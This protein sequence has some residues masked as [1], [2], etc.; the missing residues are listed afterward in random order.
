MPITVND[1]G[2]IRKIGT[3]TTNDNGILRN[4]STVSVNDGGVIRTV[5]SSSKVK[6]E[7]ITPLVV[8]DDHIVIV[9]SGTGT[10]SA[11]K[12][13]KIIM[14]GNGVRYGNFVGKNGGIVGYTI[15]TSDIINAPLTVTIAAKSARIRNKTTVKI[16]TTTYDC[17]NNGSANNI[18]N[19]KWGPIGGVGGYGGDYDSEYSKYY[20]GGDGT[21]AGGGGG[22][23][24]WWQSNN[25]KGG[26]Y[27]GYGNYG[28]NGGANG[29]SGAAGADNRN[30]YG[31]GGGGYAAGGGAGGDDGSEDWADD[32]ESGAGI[33]V[34][35][36]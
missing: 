31:G 22:T 26:N 28:G 19:S 33:V 3:V 18:I 25:G 8:A 15:L 17:T 30:Q 32:G 1:G 7:G 27:G 23:A 2:V 13:T 24:D 35:E 20:D 12:G 6:I 10:I 11:P 21:G 16:G 4:N 14:G 5:F 9:N 36:W 34:I 29:S